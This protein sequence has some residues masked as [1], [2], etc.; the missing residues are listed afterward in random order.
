MSIDQSLHIESYKKRFVKITHA[1]ATVIIH[2][3]VIAKGK[4]KNI[5]PV[6]IT[7]R[8]QIFIFTGTTWLWQNTD[9]VAVSTVT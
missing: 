5:K 3:A 6:D 7:L 2:T 8:E 9:L 4:K 1:V